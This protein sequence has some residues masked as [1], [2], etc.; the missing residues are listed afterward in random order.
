[1]NGKIFIDTNLWFYLYTKDPSNKHQL[2]NKL[3][4]QHFETIILSV[5]VTGELFNSLTKKNYKTKNEAETVIFDVMSSF[6]VVNIDIDTVLHAIEISKYYQYTYWDSSIIATAILNNCHT[7]FSEDLQHNQLI[8]NTLK[9]INP[10]QNYKF[11]N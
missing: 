2:I 9:I 6:T 3:I 4:D 7:L 8:E 5:Q 1:M 11:N 10:F